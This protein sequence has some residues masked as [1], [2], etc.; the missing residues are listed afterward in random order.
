[1]SKRRAV[2]ASAGESGRTVW[3]LRRDE[4]G[5][6]RRIGRGDDGEGLGEGRGDGGESEDDMDDTSSWRVHRRHVVQSA[7]R[8]GVLTAATRVHIFSYLTVHRTCQISP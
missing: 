3:H 2:V 5:R 6:G 1:M 4:G 7:D 8:H